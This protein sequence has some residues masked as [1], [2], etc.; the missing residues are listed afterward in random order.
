M[1]SKTETN[2][3]GN[4]LEAAEM[5]KGVKVGHAETETHTHAS[6]FNFKVTLLIAL[7]LVDKVIMF[8]MFWAM[9]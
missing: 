1:R 8:I 6:P 2:Q 5:I 9:D 7:W 4:L 3:L